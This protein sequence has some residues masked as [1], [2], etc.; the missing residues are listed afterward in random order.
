MAAQVRSSSCTVVSDLMDCSK[1]LVK[2]ATKAINLSFESF[3]RE[4][5]YCF[6][7]SPQQQFG[8]LKSVNIWQME[9]KKC[10]ALKLKTLSLFL[11]QSKGESLSARFGCRCNLNSSYN[12]GFA[13]SVGFCSKGLFRVCNPKT[14]SA[15]GWLFCRQSSL[16][17]KLSKVDQFTEGGRE[18]KVYCDCPKNW[19]SQGCRD[20]ETRPA[21]PV[22]VNSALPIMQARYYSVNCLSAAGICY[23]PSTLINNLDGDCEESSMWCSSPK[24]NHLIPEPWFSEISEECGFWKL[25]EWLQLTYFIFILIGISGICGYS[26]EMSIVVDC[27]VLMQTLYLYINRVNT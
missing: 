11:S 19:D 21:C 20:V 15:L 8:V 2:T 9:L 13:F 14:E 17:S 27:Y 12:F 26:S 18:V 5:T 10:L 6:Q 25:R 7:Y 24:S 22:P 1:I 3:K 16:S 4:L 23:E